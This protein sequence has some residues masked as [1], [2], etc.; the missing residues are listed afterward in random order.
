MLHQ[1][2]WTQNADL[3]NRCLELPFVKG[4][5]DGTLSQDRFQGYV[6]QDA[7]FLKAFFRAYSI[8]S[9]KCDSF[10]HARTFH[11]LAAG[12][13]EELKLHA[14]FA[15]TMNIDLVNVSPIPACSAYT[16]FLLRVAWRE[17]LAEIV[18]AMVPCMR[19]YAHI[20]ASLAPG[21]PPG[22][23]YQDWI[24]TY[25]SSEFTALS[26]QL[27]SLL[28]QIA[29]DIPN[30]LEKQSVRDAYRY[31]LQCEFDFFAAPM[32]NQ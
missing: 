18:A 5:G 32:D 30:T 15:A 2:L 13:L 23:R 26:E 21:S 14:S 10:E 16:D 19:L 22:N 7:F 1:E 27:E 24:T 3:V 25:S 12:V 4:I 28:D 8:A 17:S 31:A 6:A 29:R 20:G 9:A 11:Q